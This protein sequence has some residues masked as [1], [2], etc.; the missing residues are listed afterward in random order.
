[1]SKNKHDR[2]CNINR[3]E[4]S[5]NR[6][7]ENGLDKIL[8][9]EYKRYINTLQGLKGGLGYT[10]KNIP[11]EKLFLQCAEGITGNQTLTN[12]KALSDTKIINNNGAIHSIIQSC[13]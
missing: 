3:L 12:S 10:T 6:W 11:H 5:M 8:P 4:K 13:L 7:R 9:D 2:E 1:M